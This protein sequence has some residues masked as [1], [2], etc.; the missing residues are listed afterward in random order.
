MVGAI[1]AEIS[2]GTPGGIGRLIIEYA[3]QATGDPARVYAADPRRRRARPR[4]GRRRSRCSTSRL[5][6]YH[7]QEERDVTDAGARSTLEGVGKRFGDGARAR[8][9]P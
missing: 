1:V 9:R 3:Q 5:R 2:T 8:C 4:R 7:A 6:R